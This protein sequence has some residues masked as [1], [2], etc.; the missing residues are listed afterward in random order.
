MNIKKGE[1]LRFVLAVS[2]GV[3]SVVLLDKLAGEY[4][5]GLTVAHFDHGIRSD[6]AADA[7]FVEVL[8]QRYGVEFVAK[9]EELGEHA[10][11]DMARQRRYTFLRSEAKKRGAQ[12]VTAHHADDIVET[13][14]INLMR[15]TGWRGLAVLDAP[16]VM[17][18][19]APMSKREIRE[20]ALEHRL[21]W[22]EDGTN[23]SDVYLRNRVRRVV[24]PLLPPAQKESLLALWRR[25]LQLKA[26]IRDEAA[27]F[28]QSQNLS[29]YFFTTIDSASA[30]EILRAVTAGVGEKSRLTRPQLERALL[31]VKTARPGATYE[32]GEGITIDF[33]THTFIVKTP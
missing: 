12:L 19:L 29:R 14:A 23:A 28:T 7:R 27:V 16:D 25:Q 17:R 4:S 18:P 6:S 11:E 2:G 30:C 26:V 1:K 33:T 15:G 21:E 22:V 5:E 20:Y 10:S 32:A 24:T 31:A 3:D 9:R 13:I 8:A